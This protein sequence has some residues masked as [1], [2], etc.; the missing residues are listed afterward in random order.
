M[1]ESHQ[2]PRMGSWCGMRATRLAEP[3]TVSSPMASP[4]KIP[5]RGE[6]ER[7][8]PD[9][10]PQGPTK[11]QKLRLERADGRRTGAPAPCFI[12]RHVGCFIVTAGLICLDMLPCNLW[13]ATHLG[14][15]SSGRPKTTN[16]CRGKGGTICRT[17]V[18][19]LFIRGNGGTEDLGV[20]CRPHLDHH[21][22]DPQESYLL[23]KP[24]LGALYSLHVS[25][26]KRQ[27][28]RRWKTDD[29]FWG[30]FERL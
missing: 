12:L 30:L 24:K 10:W 8:F 13:F 4:S 21:Q 2:T 19:R 22:K 15:T 28:G 5:N 1:N 25:F 11:F 14:P 23:Y 17:C 6:A 7:A 29:I 18:V 26:S 9:R 20:D 3:M 27:E 16:P